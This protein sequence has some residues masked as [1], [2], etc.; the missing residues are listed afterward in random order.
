[1]V[2]L[3]YV[4]AAQDRRP[5]AVAILDEAHAIAQAH[6]AHAVMGHIEQARTAI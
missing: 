1:M 5:D 2:G 6:D 4:A 3:A